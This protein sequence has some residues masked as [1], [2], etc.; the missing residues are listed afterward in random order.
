MRPGGVCNVCF[1]VLSKQEPFHG[2]YMFERFSQTDSVCQRSP[3][4]ATCM[5]VVFAQPKMTIK[6]HNTTNGQ[7]SFISDSF[8]CARA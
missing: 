1:Q 2:L 6:D 5:I 7:R 8:H 3:F 4:D